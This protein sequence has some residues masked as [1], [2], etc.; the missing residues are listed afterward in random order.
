[1]ILFPAIDIYKGNAVRLLRGDYEQVTV[2]HGSRERP[3]V[4]QFILTV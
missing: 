3:P 1:M 2:Y 4:L